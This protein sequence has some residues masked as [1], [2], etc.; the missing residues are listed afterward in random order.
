M[1]GDRTPCAMVR[2]D[3]GKTTGSGGE[4]YGGLAASMGHTLLITGL[5]V[6]CW[7]QLSAF[8]LSRLKSGIKLSADG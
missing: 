6:E 5:N 3:A 4:G 1:E 7:A 8:S 2:K